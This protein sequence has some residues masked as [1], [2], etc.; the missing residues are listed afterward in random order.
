M[1]KLRTFLLCC[2]G[3][4]AFASPPAASGAES[5][6][7]PLPKPQ[8]TGGKPLMQALRERQSIRDFSADKLSAQELSNLLWA[9]FGVNRP[10]TG[11]RTAP[12]AMNWQ[13]IDLFVATADGLFLYD[14]KGNAL[15]PILEED[16]RAATGKQGFVSVAAVSLVYVA[17]LAR[18]ASPASEEKAFYLGADAGLIAENVYLFCSSFGLATVVR[19]SVDREGLAKKMRLRPDQRV[20]LAQ[21]VGHPS[22][23]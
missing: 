4:L 11:K 17:D 21:S 23:K 1:K 3:A 5:K 6:P 13:E 15:Q 19:G 9:A 18:T 20:I 2:L 22:K 16:V 10:E 14:P 12:S 7:V 8:M